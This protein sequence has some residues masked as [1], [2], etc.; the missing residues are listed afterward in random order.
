MD[1]EK[2]TRTNDVYPQ[3]HS[4]SSPPFPSDEARQRPTMGL[5]GQE[6]NSSE[7]RTIVNQG[8]VDMKT[9]K[10]GNLSPAQNHGLGDRGFQRIVRNFTPS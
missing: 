10:A 9:E 7:G 5:S 2:G 3:Y 4:G 1:E 8:S 6:S